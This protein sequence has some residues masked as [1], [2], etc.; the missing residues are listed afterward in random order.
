V[1]LESLKDASVKKVALGEPK[2]VPV[3]KYADE[4]LKSFGI[5]DAISKKA[6]Y[7]KSVKEVLTW[8][9]TGNVD[10]GIVYYSDAKGNDKVRIAEVIDEKY[11]SK[12]IFPMAMIS[13]SENKDAA[14]SFMEFLK[15]PT[16]R[17]VF[18]GY[19]FTFIGK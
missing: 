11:H 12:V 5:S 18:E 14:K 16:S 9:E 8:V 2:S 4:A 1:S 13:G 6:V 3:G 7:G 19:G 17:N 15:S 10:A